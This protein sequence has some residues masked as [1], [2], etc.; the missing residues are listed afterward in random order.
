MASNILVE[1]LWRSKPTWQASSWL[2]VYGGLSLHEATSSLSVYG[3]L[4]LHEATSSLSV[5]GGLSLQGKQHL[6]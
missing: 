3:G 1:C 2:S 4:S 5:Y 6:R